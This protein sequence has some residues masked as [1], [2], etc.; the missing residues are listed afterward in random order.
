MA[1]NTVKAGGLGAKNMRRRLAEASRAPLGGPSTKTLRVLWI[2]V[3]S[4]NSAEF[5]YTANEF[6]RDSG[7]VGIATDGKLS[8]KMCGY[9]PLDAP[10]FILEHRAP[11][12]CSRG[13][14]T[15]FKQIGETKTVISEGS[16]MI[17]FSCARPGYPKGCFEIELIGNSRVKSLEVVATEDVSTIPVIP[18]HVVQKTS[19]PIATTGAGLP[20]VG[21]PPTSPEPVVRSAVTP[22]PPI[23]IR[24]TLPPARWAPL[25]PQALPSPPVVPVEKKVM[26]PA[27]ALLEA[28]RQVA[29]LTA[30]GKSPKD[31]VSMLGLEYSKVITYRQLL[32]LSPTLREQLAESVP[33]GQRMRTD[34][35]VI[36][37]RV[38]SHETQESIW[39]SA[40]VEKNLGA[41]KRKVLALVLPVV[42]G[43]V[44]A[45]KV[46]NKSP[47]NE[48]RQLHRA[49]WD[50]GCVIRRLNLCDLELLV[51]EPEALGDMTKPPSA[52]IIEA[53]DT[54]KA[55]G[56]RLRDK[57]Q[58]SAKNSTG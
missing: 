30:E 36:L 50:I 53:G 23:I 7:F 56:E 15:L 41:I 40:R 28:I 32:K 47:R 52:Q 54:I 49:L 1:T 51:D 2:K 8:N 16:I 29:T 58:S 22:N 33:D 42:K 48:N 19:H 18:S 39:E 45:K 5:D 37:S 27:L 35:G 3:A 43:Q 38:D 13:P 46:S 14:Y 17:G 10:V 4:S 26:P 31:V 11:D 20:I 34:T 9:A 21:R 55:F 25:A 24:Q 44:K 57:T 6:L 12:N